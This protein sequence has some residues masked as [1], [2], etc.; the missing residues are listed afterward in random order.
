MIKVKFPST[1]TL[2]ETTQC[3][4]VGPVTAPIDLSARC[5]VQDN[6]VSLKM[7]FG[8][9]GKYERGGPALIFVFS[10]GG[11]NPARPLDSG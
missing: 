3:D 9:S 11:T 7:P 10:S 6:T 1:I 8:V 5:Y 4:L 2:V